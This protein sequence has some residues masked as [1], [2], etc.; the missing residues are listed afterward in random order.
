MLSETTRNKQIPYI[1]PYGL[2]LLLFIF[3]I[4]E[5][6]FS[7]ILF[8]DIR[9]VLNEKAKKK[10]FTKFD[11]AGCSGFMISIFGTRWSFNVGEMYDT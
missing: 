10:N 3:F 2:L 1:D 7:G 11:T 4:R 9:S 8:K 6:N 5:R